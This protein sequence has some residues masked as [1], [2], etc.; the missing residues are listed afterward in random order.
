MESKGRDE[1]RPR[2]FRDLTVLFCLFAALC[3]SV[4][5]LSRG[6]LA[7]FHSACNER[8]MAIPP[9]PDLYLSPSTVYSR[10][11]GC[12]SVSILSSRKGKLHLV[13]FELAML[14]LTTEQTMLPCSLLGSL[15]GVEGLG[16]S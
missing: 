8:K 10:M 4:S 14:E 7:F 5:I 2:T 3:T 6:R 11:T 1:G 9:L 12:L 16:F 15:V 13:W